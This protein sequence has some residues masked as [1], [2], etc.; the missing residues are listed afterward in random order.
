MKRRKGSRYYWRYKNYPTRTKESAMTPKWTK[1]KHANVL[2]RHERGCGAYEE[3]R[4]RCQ[5]KYRAE[6][7]D[8]ETR[9]PAKSPT[10][11]NVNEAIG[12]AADFRR[13]ID[14]V[15][16]K[17]PIGATT[18]DEFM[19]LFFAA[20][21][22]GTAMKSNGRRYSAKTCRDY[23]ADYTRS[24]SPHAGHKAIDAMDTPAWQRVIEAIAATGQRDK[25]GE[26][27]GEAYSAHSL[28][29]LMSSVRAAYRW[30]T[31]P[32]NPLLK[33]G[34]V[35]RD[36]RVPTGEPK[37]NRKVAAPE[38]VPVMLGTIKATDV[39]TAWAVMFYTG[40]RISEAL[41]LTWADVRGGWVRVDASKSE[42]G[43][44]RTVPIVPPLAAALDAWRAEC[45]AD[46][47]PVFPARRR[48]RVSVRTTMSDETVRQG[49]Y[50]DWRAAG[51]ESVEPHEARHSFASMVV[52]NRECSLEDLRGWLGHANI[53]QTAA[54]VHTLPGARQATAGDRLAASFA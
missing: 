28:G 25:N 4:C 16:S 31:D 49:A 23:E 34:N 22:A 39:R 48:T 11:T 6:I 19:A 29:C 27:I 54:Y 26:P 53:A 36:L 7:Y 14:P 20:M 5:P 41:A 2:V 12:W 32:S 44:G 21:K 52:A 40:L 15:P 45:G 17:T 46:I 8:R 38:L 35:T 43:R 30:G 33:G 42:N 24:V 3:K 13:G 37:K 1:T 10:Y 18:V 47:G 50:R 9:R 51:V